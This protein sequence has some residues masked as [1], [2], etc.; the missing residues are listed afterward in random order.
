MTEAG[1]TKA[2]AIF[3]EAIELSGA[4]RQTYL[5]RACA[6]N[7]ELLSRVKVLLRGAETDDQFL[8][9]PTIS[10]GMQ[11]IAGTIEKPGTR[12]GPYKL[13][14]PIGEGGFGSVFLAEQ[15][16][17]VRRRVAL[18]IIKLGMDT[19][20]VVARFEQERQALAMMD[21]PNIAKVFDAGATSTGRPYFV[22]E[23]VKGQ[24]IT[25]YC[26]RHK[27]SIAERLTLFIQVCSAVQ[28][29]HTKGIIHRD[30]KPGNVLVTEHGDQGSTAIAKVIDFGIAKAVDRPL[31]D[32]TVFTEQRQLIGTPEYM[33]PEQAEGS[34]DLDTRTDVYSLGVVLYELLAGLPPFDPQRLRSAA[35]AEVQ[36]IIRE[37]DPP[38]PS[39][40]LSQASSVASSAPASPAS[41][42]AA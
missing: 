7:A 15:E 19:R 31:T 16:S 4:E 5:E 37:V 39:T 23:L 26:D 29:A 25:E 41:P 33:S 42:P 17:P 14:E 35:Y 13:L 11:T 9:E 18:K 36:R 3:D 2:K 21:H 24:P 28:H 10:G 32:K 1:D 27:L 30:L 20:A 40:R 12:I 6:G 38:K 22:M 34:R 8:R